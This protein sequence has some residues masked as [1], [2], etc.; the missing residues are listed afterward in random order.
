MKRL[1]FHESVGLPFSNHVHGKDLKMRAKTMRFLAGHSRTCSAVAMEFT[2]GKLEAI[3]IQD[4]ASSKIFSSNRPQT[5]NSGTVLGLW[6][7]CPRV[8]KLGNC[9]EE[10]GKQS[11]NNVAENCNRNVACGCVQA[12]QQ[13]SRYPS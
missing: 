9:S 8:L 1:P 13:H 3:F 5:L 4:P 11:S 6:A 12:I 2:H 7:L 10:H